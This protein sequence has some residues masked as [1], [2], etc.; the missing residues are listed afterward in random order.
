VF[1]HTM[2]GPPPGAAVSAGTGGGVL[3]APFVLGGCK[4]LSDAEGLGAGAL[5]AEAGAPLTVT[6]GDI[7]LI[8]AAET[9]TLDTSATDE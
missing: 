1:T 5:L 2:P 8:E 4:G 3:L 7:F 9:P 6:M